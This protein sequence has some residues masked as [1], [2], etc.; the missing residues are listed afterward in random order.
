MI[1]IADGLNKS[2][3]SV[4]LI[5]L[6]YAI[7]LLQSWADLDPELVAIHKIDKSAFYLQEI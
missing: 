4:A 6:N 2:Y 3:N 1:K 7:F 5:S